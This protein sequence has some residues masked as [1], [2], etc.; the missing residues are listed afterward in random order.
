[1][2]QKQDVF[3]SS[4]PNCEIYEYSVRILCMV[5]NA[6]NCSQ[7]NTCGSALRIIAT[8]ILAFRRRGV[9]P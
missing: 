4:N 1:M 7:L 5:L 8:R 3:V 6:K 9:E 2:G